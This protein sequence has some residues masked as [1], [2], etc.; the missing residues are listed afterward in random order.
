[1]FENFGASQIKNENGQLT[2]QAEFN[3]FFP[4]WGTDITQYAFGGEPNI[5]TIKVFGSFQV[6]PWDESTAVDLKAFENFG[7]I[8][9]TTMIDISKPG[10]YEYKY[11]VS[12]KN[13]EKRIV[14]DPFTKYSVEG[15]YEICGFVIDNPETYNSELNK[16]KPFERKPLKDLIIYE[17]FIN[18]FTANLTAG[19][20]PVDKVIEKI[21][22]NYFQELGINAIEFMPWTG[23]LGDGFSWGYDPF[24]FFSVENSY[25]NDPTNPVRKLDKLIELINECHAQGIH[26]IMD[27]VFNHTYADYRGK[28][29]PYYSL[30]QNPGDCPFIGAFGSGGFFKEFDYSNECTHQFILDV[31]KYWIN[32]FGIDGIRLDYTMGYY[33]TVEG[34][35]IKKL[36]SALKDFTSDHPN[37]SIIIEHIDWYK[38]IGACLD[39]NADA[40][41]YEPY[42]WI[43]RSALYKLR[44]NAN[45]IEANIMRMLNTGSYFEK[46]YNDFPKR[47]PITYLE[48][49]DHAQVASNAEGQAHWY[50]TQPWIISLFTVAGAPMIHN[51]QEFADDYWL[52]ET[53]GDGGQNRV[54]PRPVRWIEKHDTP[55]GQA[56]L[57]FY[58]KLIKI[59]KDHPG[60]S[61]SY[62]EP[63]KWD[64]NC[65]GLNSEG[66]GVSVKENIV[67]FHRWGH[68]QDGDIE[69]FYII[70]NFTDG[71]PYEQKS[72]TISVANEGPWTDLLSDTGK[73]VTAYFD[74][75]IMK[76]RL[77]YNVPSNYGA[78]LYKK[79]T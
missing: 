54:S 15:A 73:M 6:K 24:L 27:G 60:L 47:I 37:F 8:V 9:W 32:D 20:T 52:P 67:V 57:N 11:I 10:F 64:E 41:W 53:D 44:N 65:S 62:F 45:P 77:T 29:F 51:G 59:R 30:Y 55:E 33:D 78:I 46:N 25:V 50:R 36:V 34:K 38:A 31:C 66:Y 18:D 40:C 3:L 21:K 2:L 79:N 71:K 22:S 68:L 61:S 56:V 23:W 76:H 74:N 4:K 49:H 35:G 39:I 26:V 19:I 14:G 12:F 75:R 7:G 48:T 69:R 5:D 42:Y 28:G 43:S 17:L 72:V 1:M 63:E 70:L 13:G 58:K 16:P